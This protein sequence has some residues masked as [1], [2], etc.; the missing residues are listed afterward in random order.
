MN[1]DLPR[2]CK[3]TIFWLLSFI[4]CSVC[5]LSVVSETC[6][7]CYKTIK[8]NSSFYTSKGVNYCSKKCL[9]KSRP[10]CE[11]CQKRKIKMLKYVGKNFCS[12]ACVRYFAPKCAGC[13]QSLFQK[14][15]FKDNGK[16]YC[17]KHCLAKNQPPC[18]TC[19]AQTLEFYTY[20]NRRYCPTCSKL[21]RCNSCTHPSKGWGLN[22]GRTLCNRCVTTGINTFERAKI[23]YEKVRKVLATKF[24]IL[25][26]NDISLNLVNANG[27]K[28]VE[29][30]YNENERGLY[31]HKVDTLYSVGLLGGKKVQSQKTKMNIYILSFLPQDMFREVVAHELMHNWLA[32][33]YPEIKD[34]VIIEGM[35]EFMA[36]LINKH[37]G[38]LSRNKRMLE[39]ED[40]V[41]GKG[42]R[43]ILRVTRGRGIEGLKS[44]LKENYPK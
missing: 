21:P 16:K 12:E 22:D 6:K 32:L 17:S 20:L 27:L 29:H 9:I 33:N 40:E 7:I 39:N 34:P 3:R 37:F 19:G 28:K 14:K 24:A 2:V 26:S 15:F 30:D 11:V 43:K 44:W 35:A 42:Y 23:E 18:F 25:T 36:S 5:S 4:L 41:Y 38:R 8:P 10:P 31:T 1:L 13:Q